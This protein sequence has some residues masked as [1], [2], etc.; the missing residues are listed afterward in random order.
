MD[1]SGYYSERSEDGTISKI[2][3]S[4]A[5]ELAAELLES[6]A[7]GRCAAQQALAYAGPFSVSTSTAADTEL[8]SAYFEASDRDFRELLVAVTQTQQFWATEGD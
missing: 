6:P 7:V 3:V 2:E 5:G 8:V 1:V 4:G